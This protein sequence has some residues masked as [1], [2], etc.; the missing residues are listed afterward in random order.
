MRCHLYL[1]L[2]PRPSLP[3]LGASPLCFPSPWAPI[4]ACLSVQTRPRA[5]CKILSLTFKGVSDVC[6]PDYKSAD[7]IQ[8][9]VKYH[10]TFIRFRR[11]ESLVIPSGDED[12][13]KQH[14]QML[15]RGMCT[16]TAALGNSLTLSRKG[17]VSALDVPA[18]LPFLVLHPR[19]IPT[20]APSRNAQG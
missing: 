13:E 7:G 11:V 12:M 5:R 14:S 18:A 9:T 8:A 2:P 1:R 17:D 3:G 15:S 4:I 10:L 6:F 16:G 20:H 19:E